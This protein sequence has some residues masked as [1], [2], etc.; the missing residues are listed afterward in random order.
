MSS[1]LVNVLI[2][3]AIAAMA[4]TFG[5][6]VYLTQQTFSD[7]NDKIADIAKPSPPPFP[8]AAPPSPSPPPA[9]PPVVVTR[10]RALD[11]R[12]ASLPTTNH[13]RLRRRLR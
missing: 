7:G 6:L 1:G 4:G 12:P 9:P 10:L 5:T 2:M 11:Q 8:P 3:V 13:E